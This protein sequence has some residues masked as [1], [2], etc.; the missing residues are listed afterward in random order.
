MSAEP[1]EGSVEA[2]VVE[3]PVGSAQ[4]PDGELVIARL[5]HDMPEVRCQVR[6]A[7]RAQA[8]AVFSAADFNRLGWSQ[9][10]GHQQIELRLQTAPDVAK[11]VLSLRSLIA[12]AP[13]LAAFLALC[14][15]LIWPAPDTSASLAQ[16]AAAEQR[17]ADLT[18]APHISGHLRQQIIELHKQ[19]RAAEK[20]DAATASQQSDNAR[21]TDANAIVVFLLA[22]VVALPSFAELARWSRRRKTG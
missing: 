16:V 6:Y 5:G 15:V 20:G 21:A 19:I 2:G 22:V 3:L 14:P 7:N 17:A 4:F 9:G 18:S 8:Q 12:V 1:A 13:V 11:A 10:G